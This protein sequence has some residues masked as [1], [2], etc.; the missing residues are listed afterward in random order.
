MRIRYLTTMLAAFIFL[1]TACNSQPEE[2]VV[3]QLVNQDVPVTV[4]VTR[5]VTEVSQ[6]EVPV[7][8]TVEVPV[9][10]TVQVPVEVPVTVIAEQ[11]AP[12]PE[13]VAAA[14]PTPTPAPTTAS[15]GTPYTVQSG[16]TLTSIATLTGVP[17]ADILSANN[18]TATSV[19]YAGQVLLI[20]NWD[21]VARVAPTVI[22]PQATTAPA[23]TAGNPTGG[24]LFPNPSFEQ[25]W[26]YAGYSELQIP[27]GWQVAT[28]EGAN[29]LSPGSGGLFL[30]PEI[31]VVPSSDLP[32]AE[33]GLFIFDGNKTLKAFKGY[34]PTSFSLFTDITLPPG[35]YRMVIR[36]F[37]DFVDAYEGGTKIYSVDPL[38]GEIRF[39]H[40]NGGTGWQSAVIGQLGTVTYDFTV[41]AT[42]TVRLGASFRNRFALANNGWFL[43][44][45]ELNALT[46]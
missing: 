43:D 38:A 14:T 4:E 35:S 44:H 10:V 36:Y 37:G 23:P 9:E 18:L 21:G 12:T 31:R 16:D 22:A 8:I 29:T 28:D 46:P 40:G 6:V 27:V 24:N 1:L 13:T 32:P 5:I 30:R 20:P 33:H 39:I 19:I 26:Y 11:A 3:T 17:A 15:A 2:I 25:D 41:S 42:E 7:E 34:G 45:W